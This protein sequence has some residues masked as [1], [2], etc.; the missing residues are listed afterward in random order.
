MFENYVGSKSSSRP[1]RPRMLV[2]VSVAVHLVAVLALLIHGMWGIERLP[3]PQRALSVAVAAALPPPPPAP[4]PA[5]APETPPAAAKARVRPKHTTQ[6]VDAPLEEPEIELSAIA[7]EVPGSA[8]PGGAADHPFA[9]P[10]GSV[11]SLLP[12]LSVRV[13]PPVPPTPPVPP[14]PPAPRVVDT[15]AVEA[16]RIAGE[17]HI[18]PDHATKLAMARD[19]RARVRAQVEMCLS[20]Q[21]AVTRTRLVHSSGYDA[22]DAAI[23]ARMRSWRYRPYVVGGEP[24]PVCTR[25]T[26]V[27]EQR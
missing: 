24:A 2:G 1:G 12:A 6:P 18:H 16:R 10:G 13:P 21:G 8:Q 15:G 9:V 20:A 27:Y 3:K 26:F 17:A 7:E 4:A 19:G 5:A 23:Q 11:D 25:V 22:Y 14:V